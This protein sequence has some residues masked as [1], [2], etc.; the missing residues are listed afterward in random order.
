ML[1]YRVI[2]DNDGGDVFSAKSASYEDFIAERL[3]NLPG[4]GVTTL[5]Y[6]TVSSGFSLF[7]HRTKLGTLR[8]A[9]ESFLANNITG[10]LAAMGTD[11]L[12]YA[13]RFCHE[14]GLEIFWGMRMNDTHDGTGQSYSNSS[15]VQNVFKHE[16]PECLLG[17]EG[18]YPRYGAWTAVNYER[19]LVGELAFGFVQE[20]LDNYDI[21]GVQ[22]DFFRHPVFFEHPANGEHATEYEIYLMTE[23]VGKIADAVHAKG[24]LLSIR[25]PDSV[26]YARFLGLDVEDWMRLGYI[27]LLC[28]T[29]YVQLNDWDYSVRWGHR[30]NIPVYPSL[31]EVRQPS[32]AS[33]SIRNSPEA[34]RARITNC[35][36]RGSDGVLM[37]NYIFDSKN[38]VQHEMLADAM[39]P[40][41]LKTK[42]R[43]YFASFRG[44]SSIAGRA[45]AHNWF[46]RICTLTPNSP[47]A[48]NGERTLNVLIGAAEGRATA[49]ITVD[50]R[51][52]GSVTVCGKAHHLA[53][54]ENRFE[55]EGLIDGDNRFVFNG[56]M[57]VYDIRV[58]IEP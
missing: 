38:K 14:H 2:V 57:A 47:M 20:V 33:Q 18:H 36:K 17:S 48:V 5:F 34:M 1:K 37:F 49:V 12:E 52:S 32:A 35:L 23:L 24:K 56:D 50:D 22:L 30:S 13:S 40:D 51:A 7:S 41:K 3:I 11:A 25:V 54:G 16:H 39:Q 53:P 19:P 4:T 8:V 28:T 21:D 26:D 10:D 31:D 55:I 58:D 6:T 42:K 43:S 9:H 27:D 15:F 29:S 46:Q 45:P 44:V